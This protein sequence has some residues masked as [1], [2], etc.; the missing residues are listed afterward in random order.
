MAQRDNR[1]T[2]GRWHIWALA[3]SAHPRACPVPPP[4]PLGPDQVNVLLLYYEF[5]EA[6]FRFASPWEHGAAYVMLLN[7]EVLVFY[8]SHG[9]IHLTNSHLVKPIS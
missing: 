9:L 5:P 1:H 7:Q 3:P 8:P 6:L 2:V 4:T